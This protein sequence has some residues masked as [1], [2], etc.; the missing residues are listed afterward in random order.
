MKLLLK[1]LFWL[2]AIAFI[3]A[4]VPDMY[5]DLQSAL[6]DFAGGSK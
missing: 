5:S 4:V 2:L 1:A 3:V 6:D